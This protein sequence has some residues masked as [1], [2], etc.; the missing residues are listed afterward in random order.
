MI[1]PAK[2]PDVFPLYPARMRIE[3]KIIKHVDQLPDVQSRLA[4][5][6]AEWGVELWSIG[7]EFLNEYQGSKQTFNRYR[8][9]VERFLL[10]SILV[11][12]NNPLLFKPIDVVDYIDFIA[13]P[14]RN[15]IGYCIQPRFIGG[16]INQSWRPFV[17]KSKKGLPTKIER[18]KCYELKKRSLF[19]A[20]A[21]ISSFYGSVVRDGLC[22]YNPVIR[23]RMLTKSLLDRKM[24][25]QFEGK[26][27]AN[28]Q[29]Q[30]LLN[31][32]E[33]LANKNSKHERTLFLI[34]S[35]KALHLRISELSS[36]P[37]HE[38]TFKD[39][40]S[41][42]NGYWWLFVKGREGNDRNIPLPEAY[43]YYLKRYRTY[44]KLTPL[45]EKTGGENEPIIMTFQSGL[46]VDEKKMVF[47]GLCVRQLTRIVQRAF[48]E[49]A[50]FCLQSGLTEDIKVFKQATPRM[51]LYTGASMAI[52]SGVPVKYVSENLGHTNCRLAERMSINSDDK[53]R[54]VSC[55]NQ[56][57]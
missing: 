12:Q 30:I 17:A 36:N 29:W 45:P 11:K 44:R 40:Y 32:T 14:S 1:K 56:V 33:R 3:S 28:H 52:E 46:T 24:L 57:I 20:T 2:Y 13:S 37:V 16:E 47:V 34:V 7:A 10:W 39:F 42:R 8:T 50:A 48:D 31:S 53:A 22:D 18:Q 27:F 15:W 51:L 35:M 49:A 9:E 23:A 25:D 41:D 38:P 43:L 55:K 54:A 21:S 4:K 5:T 26:R 6:N 19:S